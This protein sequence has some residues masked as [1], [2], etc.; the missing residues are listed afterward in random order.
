VNEFEI[1]KARAEKVLAEHGGD[2]DKALR[3]LVGC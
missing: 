2:I 1:P 3:A